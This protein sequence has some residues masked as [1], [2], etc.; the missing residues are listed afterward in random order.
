MRMRGGGIPFAY[1]VQGIVS[2]A[3]VCGGARWLVV[4]TSAWRPAATESRKRDLI[5]QAVLG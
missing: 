4:N 2:I 3:V 5:C 1:V